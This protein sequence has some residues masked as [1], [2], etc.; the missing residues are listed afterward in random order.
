MDKYVCQ[1]CGYIYDPEE[2]DPVSGI[3]AG[4]PFEDL[5]DD[6]VCPVCGVG[7]DQFKK[8]D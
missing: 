6:W 1:M 5:P 4:T 3:E 7:K 8:M 2:G